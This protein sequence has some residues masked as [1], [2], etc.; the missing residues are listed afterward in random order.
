MNIEALKNYAL[1]NI[2]EQSKIDLFNSLFDS[3]IINKNLL[4][5]ACI[6]H[7]YDAKFKEND[8][9]S[10]NTVMDAAIEFEVSISTVHNTIYKYRKVTLRF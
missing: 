1:S 6:N 5:K 3:N 2:K 7:F 8:C 9:H 10:L 4:L